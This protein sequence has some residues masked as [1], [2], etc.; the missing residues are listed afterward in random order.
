MKRLLS[1]LS[2]L[3]TKTRFTYIK[4]DWKGVLDPWTIARSSNEQRFVKNNDYK[5]N[6]Q[7]EINVMSTLTTDKFPLSKIF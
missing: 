7:T 3:F 1:L 2:L 4:I 5:C 6:Y